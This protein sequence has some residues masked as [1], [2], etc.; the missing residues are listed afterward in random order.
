AQVVTDRDFSLENKCLTTGLRNA[1]MTQD[2]GT[3]LGQGTQYKIGTL[4]AAS[5][6]QAGNKA[7]GTSGTQELAKALILAYDD[8][9]NDTPGFKQVFEDNINTP[10][11]ITVELMADTILSHISDPNLKRLTCNELWERL[12][13]DPSNNALP[14]CPNTSMRGS[15][16][17]Q[18]LP[19]P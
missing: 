2:T 9:S 3:F 1:L 12:N 19:P 6:Y 18:V 15:M 13:L 7:G 4:F 8:E 11:N 14:H 16:N 10:E 5:L 17:C